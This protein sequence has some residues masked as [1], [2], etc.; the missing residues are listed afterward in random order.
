MLDN[1]KNIFNILNKILFFLF[2]YYFLINIHIIINKEK[3]MKKIILILSI[4]ITI[5]LTA[6][7]FPKTK[8][9]TNKNEFKFSVLAQGKNLIIEVYEDNKLI[10]TQ[11]INENINF[12]FTN[13]RNSKINVFV[14]TKQNKIID[15]RTFQF[16][17]VK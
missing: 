10:H 9:Q 11:H 8:K 15:T 12:N 4:I 7:T 16:K 1:I 6:I 5:A 14:K 3:H 17:A 2:F 13:S